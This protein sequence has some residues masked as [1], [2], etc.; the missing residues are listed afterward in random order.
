MNFEQ[1]LILSLLVFTLI[2]E[3]VYQWTLHRMV[4]KLMSRNFYDFQVAQGIGKI[5]KKDPKSNITAFDGMIDPL[6]QEQFTP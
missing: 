2:R 4:N 5:N 1:I 6:L 3:A